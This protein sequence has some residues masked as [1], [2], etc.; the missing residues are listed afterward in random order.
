[1]TI[2]NNNQSYIILSINLTFY[3][4]TKLVKIQYHFVCDNI[5]N[6]KINLVFCR[7]KDMIVDVL[8]KDLIYKKHYKF[9]KMMQIIKL[10]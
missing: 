7:A 10:N 5:E 9:K 8:I 2:F 3:T 1:M 4:C 6:N